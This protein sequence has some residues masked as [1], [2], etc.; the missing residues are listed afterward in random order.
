MV[1]H[2]TDSCPSRGK[3]TMGNKEF[4]ECASTRSYSLPTMTRD[5]II[6]ND[7]EHYA[8]KSNW[9]S[10]SKACS[11]KRIS[12][13]HSSDLNSSRSESNPSSRT[14]KKS[15]FFF[16]GNEFVL[17]NA[18]THSSLPVLCNNERRQP[19]IKNRNEILLKKQ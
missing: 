1:S 15:S 7:Y 11:G 12:C 13:M 8:R 5:T 18:H 9:L 3:H 6:S 2:E 19:D 17:I 14:R 4:Q 16:V 10:S